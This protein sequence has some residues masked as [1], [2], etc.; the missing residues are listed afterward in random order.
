MARPRGRSPAVC[1]RGRSVNGVAQRL[2]GLERRCARG[3]DGDCLSCARVSA[4]ACCS[5]SGGEGSESRDGDGL[6]SGKRVGDGRDDCVEG[7]G[8]IGPG[9][10]RAGGD[11]RTELRAIHGFP[12]VCV[13]A[14]MFNDARGV[15]E[16]TSEDEPW[17]AGPAHRGGCRLRSPEPGVTDAVESPVQVAVAAR[18]CHS[19]WMIARVTAPNA[20][21]TD[22]DRATV[23]SGAHRGGTGQSSHHPIG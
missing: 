1:S 19:A 5:I 12:P 15:V 11:A 3:R 4:L 6:A 7:G 16:G 18:T 14:A 20:S 2:G 8:G 13:R 17:M 21:H 10:R 9:Q 23:R 22:V